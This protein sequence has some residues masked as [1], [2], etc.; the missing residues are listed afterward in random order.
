MRKTRLK[1]QDTDQFLQ[2]EDTGKAALFLIDGSIVSQFTL[3]PKQVNQLRDWCTGFN[4]DFFKRNKV[5]SK[6]NGRTKSK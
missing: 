3:T 1:E 2:L 6:D 4:E 5:T